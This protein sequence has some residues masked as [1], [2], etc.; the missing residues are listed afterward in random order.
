MLHCHLRIIIRPA[1]I[2]SG[3]RNE[4]CAYQ[5]ALYKIILSLA[6]GPTVIHFRGGQPAEVQK[7]SRTIFFGKTRRYKMG[8]K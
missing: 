3:A 5:E 2:K 7:S 1:T 4:G 8:I 6:C